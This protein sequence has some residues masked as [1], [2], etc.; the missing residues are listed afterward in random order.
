MELGKLIEKLEEIYPTSMAEPWDNTG[1]MVGYRKKDVKKVMVSIEANEKLIDEA[2]EKNV[3]LIIT[4]HPLIFKK[5]TR[6]NTDDLK[7][8]EIYKLIRNDMALYSM[9]TNFDMAK[10]GMNDYFMSL[11]G[12][13][14]AKSFGVSSVEQLYKVAVFVPENYTESVREVMCRSGAGF[15]GNYS[16]CTFNIRGKGTFYPEE[17]TN[18]FL[19]TTGELEFADEVKIESVVT[20]KILKKVIDEMIKAHPYEEVAYDVYRLENEGEKNGVGRIGELDC[21]M[22]LTELAALIK[23]KLSSD[24]IRLVGDGEKIVK[25]VAVVTGAGSEFIGEAKEKRADVFITGD[26][27]YHEAQ[28]AVDMG[29]NIL[30]CGHFELEYIFKDKMKEFV[31]QNFELEVIES[32]VELNPFKVI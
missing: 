9:H 7:G 5:L 11:I 6:V 3:D 2:I 26:L 31:A 27:K 23:E 19:G 21:E 13:D 25:R 15:I 12:I 20:Q 10:D 28:D 14:G 16:S 18:P 32:E 8:R 29:V 17:G 24:Y 30:D 22:K 1:L 4:H